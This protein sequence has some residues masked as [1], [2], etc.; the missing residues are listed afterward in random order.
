MNPITFFKGKKVMSSP[1]FTGPKPYFGYGSNVNL[2]DFNLWCENN[3]KSKDLLKFKTTATLPDHELRFSFR[4]ATR[5]GG[6]LDVRPCTGQV[7]E[8][9]L[10][11]VSEE[12]IKAL[13]QKEGVNCQCYERIAIQVID[14]NGNPLDAFT[15]RVKRERA[16]AYVKPSEEYLKIVRDGLNSWGLDPNH[17]DAAATKRKKSKP[18]GFFFYGTLLRGESRFH[19][20]K[21]FGIKCVILAEMPGRLINLGDYPGLV[22][23]GVTDSFVQ[24][25]FVRLENVEKAIDSLDTI[26]GFRGFCKNGSLYR[27]T[28]VEV[29]VG[30]G[31]TRRAW[32]YSLNSDY[33]SGSI[34]PSGDWRHHKGHREEF[35]ERLAAVYSDND[36]RSLALKIAQQAPFCFGHNQRDIVGSLMPLSRAI[37]NGV[38]SE[39][40]VAMASHLWTAIP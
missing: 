7:V 10:F 23:L 20:L 35:L 38:V 15:Y 11:E 29:H 24:G 21:K 12:G 30:D 22:D 40:N 5:N 6:V 37:A 2:A 17:V 26:E 39:R 9:V 14:Q 4:S 18:D 31:R 3:G 19:L 13:D 1:T 27:R 32:T 36:T 8:G 25:E 28:V 34:I 16:E 33:S